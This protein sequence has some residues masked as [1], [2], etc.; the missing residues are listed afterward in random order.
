MALKSSIKDDAP[1]KKNMPAGR[2]FTVKEKN[3]NFELQKKNWIELIA[4]YEHF[5]NPNFIHDFFGKMTI[6]QIGI[7]AY[8]HADHHLRQFSA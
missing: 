3:G 4:E 8:K 1:M 6:E 2:G 5:S 7:F